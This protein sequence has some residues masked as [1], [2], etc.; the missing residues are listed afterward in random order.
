MLKMRAVKMKFLIILPAFVALC[1]GG[2][3]LAVPGDNSHYVE[4]ESRH[5]W[6]PDGDGVSHLVDLQASIHKGSSGR[7]AYNQY[8]L[9]TR[10]NPQNHQLMV[11]YDHYSVW[12]SNYDGYKPTKVIVHG[13]G[14]NGDSQLN[15]MIRDALLAT[16]DFN[17]IVVDWGEVAGEFYTDSAAAVP[18]IGQHLGR[19]LQWLLNNF[20]GSWKNVHLV[21]F[22]LGAHIVGNAARTVGGRVERITG[23]DPAGPGWHRNS[24][25]LNRNDGVYVEAIHTDGGIL[26][27]FEPIGDVDFYPNGGRNPQPGCFPVGSCS[28][29]RAYELFAASVRFNNFVGSECMSLDD[30]RNNNCKGASHNMGN[31]DFDKRGSGLYSLTTG[32]TWPF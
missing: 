1:A 20:G 15:P 9:Y 22:S 17:V 29:G 27:I 30:V 11:P 14:S 25:A 23:L 5:I 13:W 12:S 2:K 24:Y 3:I 31:I 26:G 19:F 10:K 32:D 28:H 6:I 4:G 21:G 7:G 16:G 18:S 8:W